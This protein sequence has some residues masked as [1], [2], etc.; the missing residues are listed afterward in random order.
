MAF[1]GRFVFNLINFAAGNA[2][3]MQELVSL[4]SKSITEL[5]QEDCLIDD[6]SYNSVIEAC[7][8][9]TGD[10]LFGLHAGESLNLSAAGLIFQ[11]AQTSKSVKEA[12]QYN[13]EFANLGCS[14]LPLS[15]EKQQGY[16]QIKLI[17]NSSWAQKSE[18]VLR[19]TA[20]GVMA[21]QIKAFQAL[22]LKLCQPIS[23]HLP[24]G[25]EADR[26]EYERVLNGPVFLKQK[27]ITMSFRN[28]DME[29]GIIT[30]NY[31]LQKVLL[32][33][34]G[35]KSSELK[36]EH[37]FGSQIKDVV[38]N[39]MSPVF[40]TIDEVAGHLNITVRTLQRRLKEEGLTFKIIIDELRQEFA[41]GYIQRADL[42]ISDIAYLLGYSD[43]SAFTRSF[44]RWTGQSPANYKQQFLLKQDSASA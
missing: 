19:Q 37:G 22:T 18:M 31:D 1:N 20:D 24:W 15:L 30:S 17:P 27:E 39:L 36:K 40:P 29:A 10:P 16:Y 9:V 44:K 11:I 4:T 8:D 42:S 43:L 6:D 7:L 26:L 38:V 12:V 21:F 13:C 14:V 25:E 32:E 33:Y 5:G 35:K 3:E 34:A 41:K 28:K 2:K 23:I